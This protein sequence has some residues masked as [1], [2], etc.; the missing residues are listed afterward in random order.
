[1]NRNYDEKH[2]RWNKSGAGTGDRFTGPRIVWIVD[3]FVDDVNDSVLHPHVRLDHVNTSASV[4]N[5]V[6]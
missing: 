1:M 6:R 2:Q 4:E 3:D 5:V